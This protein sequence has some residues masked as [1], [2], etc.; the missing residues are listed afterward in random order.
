MKTVQHSAEFEIEQPV[1]AVFPLFS[2]EGETHW[3][4]GW[5][6]ENIMGSTELCENYV[7]LTQRHDH[8]AG[9]AIWIVKAYEPEAYRVQFYK[10]E[11]EEK[12]G[13]IT[14]N[15]TPR[16]ATST[17]VEV[18]YTYIALSAAGEA[19]VAG[20]T[21]A[22]YRAYIDEWKTLLERYFAAKG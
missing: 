5:E 15:C 1:E 4:P 8:A 19:F 18:S 16:A 3:V 13:V 6:Y 12:V 21:E 20:F 10:V 9:K 7:F 11:P 2:P 22:G 14:V 17:R